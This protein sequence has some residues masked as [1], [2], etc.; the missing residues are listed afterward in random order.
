MA[1]ICKWQGRW[2]VSAYLDSETKSTQ[3][4]QVICITPP[5]MQASSA[6]VLR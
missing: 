1:A 6:I 2:Q 5:D 4:K 3:K